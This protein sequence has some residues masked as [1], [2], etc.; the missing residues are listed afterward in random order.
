MHTWPQVISAP[1]KDSGK[2]LTQWNDISD[3][4]YDR[5]SFRAVSN[6]LIGNINQPAMLCMKR[7]YKNFALNGKILQNRDRYSIN[8]LHI[9][10]ETKKLVTVKYDCQF[11]IS[12]PYIWEDYSKHQG[13]IGNNWGPGCLKPGELQSKPANA[14]TVLRTYGHSGSRDDGNALR[15]LL[16]V[17]LFA[18]AP[19]NVPSF[20]GAMRGGY[21]RRLL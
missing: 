2:L 21:I 17:S 7:N 14:A 18:D 10:Y 13:K 6:N 5:C 1:K 3:K 12:F 9:W 8:T 19:R 16:S 11:F 4:K 15:V 20:G